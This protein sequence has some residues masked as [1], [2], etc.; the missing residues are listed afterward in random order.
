MQTEAK[1]ITVM[2]IHPEVGTCMKIIRPSV[3]ERFRHF[4][5]S[6]DWDSDLL[7]REKWID[8]ICLGLVVLSA[9]YFVPVL[10]SSLLK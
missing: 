8:R 2:A 4:I 9:L 10:V 1:A 6:T 7:H 5:T 3:L